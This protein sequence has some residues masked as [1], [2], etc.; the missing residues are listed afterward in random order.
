M[1]L[2]EIRN[3]PRENGLALGRSV[4]IQIYLTIAFI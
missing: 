2:V 3:I 4:I 1:D